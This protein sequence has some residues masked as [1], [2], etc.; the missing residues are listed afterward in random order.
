MSDCGRERGPNH[1]T[2]SSNLT[3]SC[4]DSYGRYDQDDHICVMG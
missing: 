3:K 4:R 1:G 2:G